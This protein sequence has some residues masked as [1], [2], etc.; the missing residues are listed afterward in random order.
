[1]KLIS[2]TG[3]LIHLSEARALNLLQL[4]GEL[5]IPQIVEVEIKNRFP[6]WQTPEWMIV[7]LLTE[8]HAVQAATW[9]QAGFLDAGEAEAIALVR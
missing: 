3:P 7:D 4:A 9:Q 8:V 5:H 2:N 1:M 6:T